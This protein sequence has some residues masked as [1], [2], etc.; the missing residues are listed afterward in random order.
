[1]PEEFAVGPPPHRRR[2]RKI[3]RRDGKLGCLFTP[4]IALLSVTVSAMLSVS[5]LSGSDDSVTRRDGIFQSPRCRRGVPISGG[6]DRDQQNCHEDSQ[7]GHDSERPDFRFGLAGLHDGVRY[8][9]SRGAISSSAW[10]F[11]TRG[12][13][14]PVK[15]MQ[16]KQFEP[17]C[18]S[19]K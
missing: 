2:V 19:G 13:D 16:S 5:L 18:L 12:Q 7:Q 17:V 3:A 4:A 8:L 10:N 1:L 9:A 14:F 6:V 11:P 15:I